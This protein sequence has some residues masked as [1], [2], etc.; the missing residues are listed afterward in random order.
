VVGSCSGARVVFRGAKGVLIAIALGT[1]GPLVVSSQVHAK[2]R[3][4][5]DVVRPDFTGS[6]RYVGGDT[7][8]EAS[9]HAIRTATRGLF[10]GVR[11]IAR[12]LLDRKLPVAATHTIAVRETEI[13]IVGDDG[14]SR[15]APDDGRWVTSKG[16]DG[17]NLEVRHYYRGR[18]LVQLIVS[19]RG[20]RQSTYVLHP[21]TGKLLV[22]VKVVS[23]E[24]PREI[25]Y[26]LTYRRRTVAHDE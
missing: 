1:F 21:E 18:S 4:T 24:L 23:D 16:S 14:V 7:E 2:S 9:R 20:A 17:E 26:V 12:R 19:E 13:T 22:H 10:P 15:T 3:D 6:Y 5:R 8:K 11:A 25:R